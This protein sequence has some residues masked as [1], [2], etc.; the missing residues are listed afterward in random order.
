MIPT[1]NDFKCHCGKVNHA[2]AICKTPYSR[3]RSTIMAQAQKL[4]ILAQILII[5]S[6]AGDSTHNL[7]LKVTINLVIRSLK[8]DQS[9]LDNV[10]KQ[11]IER[12]ARQA[13]ESTIAV[14]EYH[15][16]NANGIGTILASCWIASSPS[17]EYRR[18]SY[19]R[20]SSRRHSPRKYSM[21]MPTCEQGALSSD[22]DEADW[23]AEDIAA[24]V[25]QHVRPFSRLNTFRSGRRGSSS[26]LRYDENEYDEGHR[27]S[28]NERWQQSDLE[29]SL[30]FSSPGS[31][32]RATRT[33]PGRRKDIVFEPGLVFDLLKNTTRIE[34]SITKIWNT[35]VEW[36]LKAVPLLDQGGTQADQSQRLIVVWSREHY[37][38]C[39]PVTAPGQADPGCPAEATHSVVHDANRPLVP[40]M[41]FDGF[42]ATIS[43]DVAEEKHFE[44][45]IV[46]F[47]E[48]VVVRTTASVVPIGRLTV[49][50]IEDFMKTAEAVLLIA[51]PVT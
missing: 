20:H 38:W 27:M 24:D 36:T 46:H 21:G 48:P 15:E 3:T 39:V 13:I 51:S 49:A 32:R 45:S 26:S 8:L 43:E 25:G 29:E 14:R 2:L 1:D 18:A 30:L 9:E 47:D 4:V 17:K 41:S 7:N 5:H 35:A 40:P 42:G 11:I 22:S 44:A 50:S 28:D 16:Y 6:R 10:D 34:N 23:K 19:L 12:Q 37:C 31:T 33:Q